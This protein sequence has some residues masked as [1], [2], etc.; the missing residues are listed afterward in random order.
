MIR[1]LVTGRDGQLARSLAERAAAVPGFDLQ[2][3]GRPDLDLERPES[4]EAAIAA[5]A[6]DAVVNAAAYTA[7]DQAEDEPERAF[8][9]NA[10][11]AGEVAA[12]ARRAGA[13]IIQVSTD[14]VFDG[15]AEGAYPES[16][17]TNPL[18]V[19]GRSKL[20]GEQKVAEANPDHL[21]LRTAWVYSPFGR[22]FVRTMLAAAHGRDELNVVDDQHGNPTSALDIADGILAILGRW[23]SEPGLGLG[24]VYHLAGSGETS[25][26]GLARQVFA[27]AAPLGLPVAQV[28][29]VRTED[30]P[31]RAVRPRNSRLD[32]AK[33][34]RDFGFRAPAW[35]A[36]VAATVRRLAS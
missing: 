26:C 32:C 29:P 12:A 33:L 28:N 14:Y 34:E 22:N 24:Q 6:P 20:D 36:S 5:T 11:A 27:E 2:A 18:G 1:I 31:T 4:I 19:Y 21:I 8:R 23:A 3:V 16:A 30:W 7:V 17:P 25:W 9:I 10:A 13:R 35:Q 15:S